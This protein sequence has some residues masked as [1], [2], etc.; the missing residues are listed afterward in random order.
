MKKFLMSIALISQESINYGAALQAKGD[1]E[2]A[3]KYYRMALSI[4]E[5]IL[6][7]NSP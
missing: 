6:D 4:K 3:F 5:A 7:T 2:K 1:L